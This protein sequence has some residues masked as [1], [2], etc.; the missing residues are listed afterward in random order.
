MLPYSPL[1]HL[2]LAD[3][4][5]TLVMT[6][7][8]VSD[9][10]IAFA[11]RRR[12]RAAAADRRLLLVPRPA[13]RDAHRR[14]GR[15]GRP[16]GRRMFLR[17]SRGYVPAA[18]PLPARRRAAAARVRRR[19][20]EHVLRRQGRR[21]R[22]SATTSA[23]SRTTRRC[24]RSPTGIE[25]FE[26]LFAVAPEVVAHDLHPEYL[27][28]KYALER[29]GVELDRRP[30][31]PRAPGGVPRRARPVRTRGRRDLRRDRLR[32]R[33]D[34]VGWRAARRR[35]GGVR[36]RRLAAGRCRCPAARARSASRGGWRVPGCA[37]R[38]SRLRR[39]RS[40]QPSTRGRW[41]LVERMLARRIAFAA[42]DQ[43]GA[44]VRRGGGAVRDPRRGQL[45]G[46]GGDR[47][48]GGVRP[49]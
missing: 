6:S 8:N 16:A 14:L 48:R 20:E 42:D 17:R 1:H 36:A 24:A 3:A 33:R 25:H 45:R 21:A 2:L 5:C 30:A 38:G 44:A 49:G 47:A 13:D 23:T 11:R 9:E 32:D 22:G 18:L 19:A 28:T 31:P 40:G 7:G 43:H 41:E 29:E 10:P 4:G 26:R 27:S 37:R 46:P 39:S 35:R 34:G 15:P 12:A